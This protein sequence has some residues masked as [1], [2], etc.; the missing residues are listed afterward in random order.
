MVN[1]CVNLIM[2]Q[3]PSKSRGP[4]TIRE[5]RDFL[6]II[7][8]FNIIF[9]SKLYVWTSWST[10]IPRD[11]TS[12][13]VTNPHR[14]KSNCIFTNRWMTGLMGR[15]NTQR[16]RTAVTDNRP[17]E[18]FASQ[19]GRS[20]IYAHAHSDRRITYCTGNPTTRSCFT[21]AFSPL[22][23]PRSAVVAVNSQK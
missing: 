10:K 11:Q 13:N 12:L 6:F 4:S 18:T 5:F 3:L 9:Q 14:I 2:L 19:L 22:S 20:I 8:W 7:V 1:M 21:S 23:T 17:I 16:W 15:V